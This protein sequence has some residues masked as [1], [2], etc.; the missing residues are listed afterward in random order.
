MARIL[1]SDWHEGDLPQGPL[2]A[3]ALQRRARWRFRWGRFVGW[4]L[5]CLL[6]IAAIRSASQFLADV[7]PGLTI[8]KWSFHFEWPALPETTR[9]GL[10]GIVLIAIVALLRIARDRFRR[11]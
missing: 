1:R 7:R 9:L 11:Q 4:P 3:T 5:A 6:A 10:L 8:P 2:P